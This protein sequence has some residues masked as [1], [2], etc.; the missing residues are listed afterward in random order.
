MQRILIAVLMWAAA[1]S[2]WA[3]V[4]ISSAWARSTVPGPKGTGAFMTIQAPDGGRQV[5]AASPV[6]GVGVHHEKAL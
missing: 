5:G 6:A 3:Q 2:A 4:S 1:G